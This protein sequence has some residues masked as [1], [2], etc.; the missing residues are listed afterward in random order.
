MYALPLSFGRTVRCPTARSICSQ[1]APD[2]LLVLLVAFD[3]IGIA[4]EGHFMQIASF[5]LPGRRF[6]NMYTHASMDVLVL[7]L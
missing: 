7:S 2:C 6:C 3:L 5:H 4:S 1:P